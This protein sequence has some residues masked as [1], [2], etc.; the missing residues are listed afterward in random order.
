MYKI[1]DWAG[2]LPFG[3]KEFRTFEDAWEMI[4]VTFPDATDQDL[5]EYEVLNKEE[6]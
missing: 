4:L 2:N 3:S 6:A 5:G 1:Y